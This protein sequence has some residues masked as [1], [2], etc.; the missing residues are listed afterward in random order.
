[1]H[2]KSILH[3]IC[4]YLNPGFAW[5]K[6]ISA[7]A[8]EAPVL[9]SFSCGETWWPALFTFA[10]MRQAGLQSSGCCTLQLPQRRLK[11]S[12]TWLAFCSYCHT[13]RPVFSCSKTSL[14][15]L[16]AT[17]K[18]RVISTFNQKRAILC[19]LNHLKVMLAPY[20]TNSCYKI[21]VGWGNNVLYQYNT[22]FLLHFITILYSTALYSSGAC[23]VRALLTRHLSLPTA[24]LLKPSPQSLKCSDLS[25][26]SRG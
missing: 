4:S 21:E 11:P 23:P 24:S 1:M 19:H 17:T 18:K 9:D 26:E 8:E 15:S 14:C 6:K 7:W 13:S 10:A 12:L 25:S 20:R 2:G 22:A 5:L 3:C 16:T